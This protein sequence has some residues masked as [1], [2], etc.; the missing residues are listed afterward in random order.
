MDEL[1]AAGP[2]AMI[3]PVDWVRFLAPFH[4]VLLHLPIGFIAVMAALELLHWRRPS[5]GLRS[6]TFAVAQLNAGAAIVVAGLGWLRAAASPDAYH[7]EILALH[8]WSGTIATTLSILAALL[9]WAERQSDR[10]RR[11]VYRAGLAALVPLI[12]FTGHQGGNLT[13]GT[14]FLVRNAPEPFRSMLLAQEA[15]ARRSLDDAEAQFVNEILPLIEARCLGCHGD[16]SFQSGFRLDVKERAYAGGDSGKPAIV[17]GDPASSNLVRALMLPESDPKAMPPA[18]L[19][20][21]SGREIG[22]I[23]DWIRS[24]AAFVDYE[25]AIGSS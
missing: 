9:L 17:P 18:G 5:E 11:A 1:F 8:R 14:N 20:R 16:T 2:T 25:K 15:G 23:I 21:L 12:L 3:G 7:V 4:F 19:P 6:A 13:H 10:P 24:G 22:L